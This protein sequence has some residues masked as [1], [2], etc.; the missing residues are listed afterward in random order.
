[1]DMLRFEE[2]KDLIGG[3]SRSTID[4]WEKAGKFPKRLHLGENVV[5]WAAEDIYKW[6]REKR[7]NA[8]KK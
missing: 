2:V 4:R 5:A 6:L 3:V 7:K 8:N 1:M